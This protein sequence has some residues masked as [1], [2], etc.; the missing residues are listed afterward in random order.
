MYGDG[1]VPAEKKPFLVDLKRSAGPFLAIQDADVVILDAASQIATMG[2]GLNHGAL[3]GAA[4]YLSSWIDDNES[5]EFLGLRKAFA[6]LLLRKLGSQNHSIAFC[7]SGAE[8]IERALAVCFENRRDKSA[9][10]VL[11]FTGSF[12]G[13][14]KFALEATWGPEKREP[15]SWP[16]QAAIF[17]P[18][19]ESDDSDP[20]RARSPVGWRE[21]WSE[22][23]DTRFASRLTELNSDREVLIQREIDSLATVR[24]TLRAKSC[25][26]I[27]IEPMQSEGGERYSSGRFHQGLASLARAFAIPL[28]YDEIQTGCHLGRSFFWHQQFGLTDGDLDFIPDIVVMAK[29]AQVGVLLS[30]LPLDSSQHICA[31]SLARGYIQASMLDQFSDEIGTIDALVAENLSRLVAQHSRL[32]GRPRNQGLAFAFDFADAALMQRAVAA[33]FQFGLVFYPAGNRTIRFR[34]N[35]AF[36]DGPIGQLFTQLDSLLTNLS[37]DTRPMPTEAFDLPSPAHHFAFHQRLVQEKLACLRG[38][39]TINEKEVLALLQVQIREVGLIDPAISVRLLD[40]VSFPRYREKILRIQAEVYEP[41]R[42]TPGEDFDRIFAAERPLAIVVEKSGAIIGMAFAGPLNQFTLVHGVSSDPLREHVDAAYMVDATVMTPYRG[43]LGRILKQAIV[44]LAIA[45][46]YRTIHGRNRDRLARGMWAINLS[47]G[48]YV[49]R[50]LKGDYNDREPFRDC[51]YYQCPAVWE[52]A[53]IHLSQG[54]AAPF[55]ISDLTAEFITRNLP[56]ATNKLTLSNFVDAD[57][58]EDLRS[59]MDLFPA[60]LRHGY[61]ASSL[62]EACDKVVKSLWHFRAP[63]KRLLIFRGHFFGDGTLLARSLSG[64]G[65][66]RYDVY[67]LEQPRHLGDRAAFDAIRSALEKMNPLALFAEPLLS[68]TMEAMPPEILSRIRVMCTRADVPLVFN[69]SAAMF[70]RYGADAFSAGGRP[71]LEPDAIVASLGSQMALALHRRSLFIHEPLKLISTW[72]GD[73]FSLAKFAAVTRSVMRDTAGFISLKARFVAALQS[74]LSEYGNVRHEFQNACGWIEGNL[75]P[76]LAAILAKNGEG[77]WLICPSQSA[78]RQF[79]EP[80]RGD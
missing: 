75:P 14:T 31:A 9:E 44:L 47:L 38:A 76:T 17:A 25:F 41:A 10:R 54:I 28:V 71:D 39:S 69:E 73:G 23:D 13:R 6:D 40:R 70:F 4:Q 68:R 60:T 18:Y 12:H 66:P 52:S 74:K 34:L 3:F 42:Q 79:I 58:I 51:L 45:K 55:G 2:L 27:L 59:A 33:R 19:P 37:G 15:F 32:I 67:A 16:E 56:K 35:L 80:T 57:F 63:R 43:G 77:R 53:D 48:S 50:H 7:N 8:A 65:E 78:M 62:S 22:R 1:V 24:Q 5:G 36:G 26:A 29:K 72:D 11:A 21:A 46:G 49:T 64:I 20:A 30:R 61:T